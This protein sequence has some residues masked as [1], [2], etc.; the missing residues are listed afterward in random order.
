MHLLKIDPKW[1]EYMAKD[2]VLGIFV[3]VDERKPAYAGRSQSLSNDGADRT[4]SQY[5]YMFTHQLQR[6]SPALAH[7]SRRVPSDCQ[8]Y[9]FSRRIDHA[10]TRAENH[11]Y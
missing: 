6:R 2:V 1:I 7:V 11:A 10:A 9:D 3:R 4:A 5:C 8:R